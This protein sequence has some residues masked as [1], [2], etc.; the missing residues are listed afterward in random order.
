[1]TFEIEEMYGRGI[2]RFDGGGDRCAVFES[3]RCGAEAGD[4]VGVGIDQVVQKISR[5]L[6]GFSSD[7]G[8][9]R[10]DAAA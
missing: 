6:I 4:D 7:A 2:F 5:R 10:A 8:E 9:I 1:M 3:E